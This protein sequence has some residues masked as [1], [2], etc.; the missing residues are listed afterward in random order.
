MQKKNSGV[1]ISLPVNRIQLFQFTYKTHLMFLIKL[2]LLLFC[3]AIPL[4][5]V[6][7]L[8]GGAEQV[9][10]KS[11]GNEI[12]EEIVQ[13]YFSQSIFLDLFYIPCFLIMGCGLTGAYSLMKRYTFG[14]GYL[15]KED[16]FQ[17][18]KE[19]GRECGMVT[20]CFSVVFY[21]VSTSKN[22]ISLWNFNY[23][24]G[25][26]VF[27]SIWKG[28]LLCAYIFSLCQIVIYRNMIFRTM[29][30]AVLFTFAELPKIA[31][32]MA[33]TYLPLVLCF[34]V[35]SVI[36]VSIGLFIYL[37]IGFGNAVLVTTLYCQSCFDRMV[38]KRFY[39]ELYRKG[40][41][42]EME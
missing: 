20:L 28:I 11:V 25:I 4:L 42:G 2:S 10:W 18:I 5:V 7:I 6:I 27:E 30:N 40:L 26:V 16:F 14:E 33:V 3:F 8:R 1:L 19:N 24:I 22:L 23:Y 38:N 39:P 37:V 31:G 36:V 41:F 34:W 29:K 15:F 12:S 17:G 13:L 9:L 21:L 32:I 35:S